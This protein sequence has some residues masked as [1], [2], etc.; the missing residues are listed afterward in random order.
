MAALVPLTISGDVNFGA[1]TGALFTIRGN[2][3]NDLLVAS[4]LIADATTLFHI[5]FDGT[6]SPTLGDTFDFINWGSAPWTGDIELTDNLDLPA[7]PAALF[8]DTSLFNTTG[9][10]SLVDAILP[11]SIVVTSPSCESWGDRLTRSCARRK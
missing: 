11:P 7:L 8:W 10:L 2:G 9:V 1:N 5:L 4:H 6:Y 3:D